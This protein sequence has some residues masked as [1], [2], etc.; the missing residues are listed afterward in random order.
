VSGLRQRRPSA[1][2]VVNF[3]DWSDFVMDQR[4]MEFPDL[5]L[6]RAVVK[7]P[8]GTVGLVVIDPEKN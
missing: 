5:V 7:E 8:R 2:P 4:E 6:G 1:K 3:P